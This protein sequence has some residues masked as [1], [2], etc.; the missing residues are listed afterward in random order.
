MKLRTK[1]CLVC[2]AAMLVL[3]QS[4]SLFMLYISQ[5][6]QLERI[7]K[8][9]YAIFDNRLKALRQYAEGSF[10]F[11]SMSEE[12]KQR[13]MRS[14][15]KE[16]LGLEYAVY[17][18]GREIFNMTPY[19]YEDTGTE[20]MDPFYEINMDGKYLLVMGKR[21]DIGP[22]QNYDVWHYKDVTE[23][24]NNSKKMFFQGLAAAFLLTGFIAVILVVVIRL[25]MRPIYSLKDSADEIAG[26]NYE[27]RIKVRRRDEIGEI[28]EDFNRMADK[29]EEHIKELAHT[30]E[31]QLQLMGSLAHELKTPMTAIIG[32]SDILLKMRLPQ[33]E[34]EKALIYIGSESRRLSRLSAKMLELTGLY[35][36]G[37][38]TIEKKNVQMKTLLENVKSLMTFRLKE[39]GLSLTV[40]MTGEELCH[41]MDEDLITSLLMNLLDNACKASHEGGCIEI[42]AWEKGI[43][44]RDEGSGI[45]EEEIGKIQEAF[46]MVD[47]SRA[48]ASGGS[49]LGL[50]LCRKIAELH[51]GRLVIESRLGEWTKV[52]FLWEQDS[53]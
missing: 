24:H 40:K 5:K 49:G 19:D 51:N 26:G 38:K 16:Y 18:E 15:S 53:R 6:D 4:F 17:E 28:S 20:N 52:S 27:S 31:R 32:Y 41:L 25:V 35:K 8:Y 46:Y 14:G 23:I 45:P 39:K 9:E 50:S 21:L 33:E 47:K 30:N 2:V 43:S 36:D 44:V 37:E 34:K 11:L 12:M 3:S 42:E 1:I 10:D 48:R 22:R 7:S 13:I 29:V